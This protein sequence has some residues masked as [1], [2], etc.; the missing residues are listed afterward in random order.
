MLASGFVTC[1]RLEGT[2][3]LQMDFRTHLGRP[4]DF[5]RWSNLVLSGLVVVTTIAAAVLWLNGEPATIALTPVYA[6]LVWALLRE[7]DPDHD[8]TALLAAA[9]TAIWGLSG[10]PITS[11]L[12]LAGLMVAARIIT[13][14]TGR[15]PLL[16]DLAAVAVFGIVIGFSLEGWAAGFGIALAIYLDDRLSGGNRLP[17]IGA[18]AL[19][20]I[21]TTVVANLTGAFPERLPSIIPGVAA[22]A[23]VAALLILVREPAEPISQVDAR[24]AAFMDRARL[25]MSRSVVAILVFLV[26][27]L[28]GLRSEGL[29]MIIVALGLAVVA[30][31][32][33]LIRRPSL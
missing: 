21:G 20:A 3:G 7:I 26:A 2:I 14:T 9:V 13:S 17:A 28:G 11:A 24:H 15:R 12:A 31:E 22:A 16:T 5:R 1:G 23:G 27:V 8:W 4:F 29:V 33:E 32:I 19:T 25:H 18:S 6:F 30:N 10:G